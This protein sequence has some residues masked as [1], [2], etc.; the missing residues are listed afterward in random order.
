MISPGPAPRHQ[1]LLYDGGEGDLL[2]RTE[3]CAGGACICVQVSQLSKRLFSR[4]V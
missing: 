1:H 4:F 3:E 2:R